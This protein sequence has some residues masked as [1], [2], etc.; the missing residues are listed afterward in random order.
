MQRAVAELTRRIQQHY[1]EATFEVGHGEDPE[2][3]YLRA[4][5]DVQDIDA[6][7]DVFID[8]LIELQVEEGISVHVIPLRPLAR[9]LE[10]LRHHPAQ[11]MTPA[12]L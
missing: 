1:P 4:I 12:T 8:R 9:V 6:V 7:V 2:G 5:V 11:S 10:T 3:I